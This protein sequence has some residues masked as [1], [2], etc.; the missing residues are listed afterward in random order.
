ML[1]TSIVAQLVSELVC[2]VLGHMR[3][4]N[5]LIQVIRFLLREQQFPIAKNV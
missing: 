4:P 1:V 2:T 3:D 5:I